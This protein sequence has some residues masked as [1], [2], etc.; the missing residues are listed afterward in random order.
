MYFSLPLEH[1]LVGF[2]LV[3]V[4][5]SSLQTEATKPLLASSCNDSGFTHCPRCYVLGT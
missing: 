4:K 1:R 2:W 3:Q 5:F